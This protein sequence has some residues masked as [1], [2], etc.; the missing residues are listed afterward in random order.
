MADPCERLMQFFQYL[1]LPEPLQATS[2]RCA[3]LATD[4]LASLPH[5]PEL[6]VGLRKLLEAKNCFVRA[7]LYKDE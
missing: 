6:T 3:M 4:M 7:Q 1:H 2:M 5:N